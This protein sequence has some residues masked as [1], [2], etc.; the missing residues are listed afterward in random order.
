VYESAGRFSG[1]V[2]DSESIIAAGADP[3]DSV[4]YVKAEPGADVD[5]VQAAMTEAL[6]D[7]PT[8]E[9]LSQTDFKEQITSSVDQILLVMVMLLSLAILI[10][11]L[12]IGMLRAVGALRRQIRTMVVLEALVIAVFGAVVGLVLGV[13]FAVAL[14]RT[15]VDQ[16]ITVLDIPWLGIVAFLVVAG[17]VGVLAAL[18][19]AFRA[20]RLN[21]LEAISTE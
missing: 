14:Q 18:W 3:G 16:G 17:V 10:A 9:V 21:V 7:N 4:V 19:P 12:G 11:V 1:F 6:A 5:V 8:V 13:W 2:V 15:L 20:G